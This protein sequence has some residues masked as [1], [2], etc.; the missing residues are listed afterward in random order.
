MIEEKAFQIKDELISIRRHLHRTP[1]TDFE[2]IKHLHLFAVNSTITEYL[3][4]PQLK[5]EQL[6]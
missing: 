4:Q 5:Q 2:E 3:I 6:P 1:E